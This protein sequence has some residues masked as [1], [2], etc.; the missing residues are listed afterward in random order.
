[1]TIATITLNP[2]VDKTFAVDRV[3]PDRKLRARGIRLYPGGGGINVARAVHRLGGQVNALWSCGG[4]S[5]EVLLEL[6][7]AEGVANQPV[8][9]ED[10]TRENL[11]IRDDSSGQQYRFGMPGPAFTT[12]ERDEW[13]RRLSHW[14]EPP[15][16]VVFSGSLPP[17]APLDWYEDLLRSVPVESHIVVDTKQ[18]ALSKALDVGVYLAKPNIHELEEVVGCELHHDDQIVEAA[19]EMIEHN[20]VEVLLISLGR[21]GAI[22]VTADEVDRLHAPAVKIRSKVGAGDSMVGGLLFALDR[23]LSLKNATRMAVAAGAAAVM[24]EGTD[25]CRREDVEHLYACTQERGDAAE[26]S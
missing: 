11:I 23:G 1:M 26:C 21:G 7:Q 13:I 3:V 10:H 18:A 15:R 2:C 19:K 20:Q 14:P 25:L 24:S 22:V 6:L 8:R 4:C 5:G 17:G 9:I 16:F 12:E